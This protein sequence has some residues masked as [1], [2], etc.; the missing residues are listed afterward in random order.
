[1]EFPKAYSKS[2]QYVLS[3]YYE[4]DMYQTTF[5]YTNL[6]QISLK[7]I[8]CKLTGFVSVQYSIRLF[9]GT[10]DTGFF[11]GLQFAYSNNIIIIII[12]I[13][14]T[15]TTTTTTTTTIIIII[16]IM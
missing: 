5:T 8:L 11:K 16:I 12:I 6:L 15:T 10:S 1:L 2:K 13:I 4:L 7:Y 14:I 9:N 3:D